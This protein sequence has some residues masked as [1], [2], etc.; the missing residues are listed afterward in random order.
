MRKEFTG[1]KELAEA[2][3]IDYYYYYFVHPYH[4]WERGSNENLKGFIR[5]YSP[6]ASDITESTQ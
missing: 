5:Q 1:H 2:I 4:S 3:F 6:K